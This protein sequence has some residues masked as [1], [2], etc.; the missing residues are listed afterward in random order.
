MSHG[1]SWWRSVALAIDRLGNA[2]GHGDDRETIS[3]RASRA[4]ARGAWW[5]QRL[6]RVL[7]WMDPGHCDDAF[8][9]AKED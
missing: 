6:C 9:T 3:E 1:G 7:D 4:R 5:G 2:L 8:H